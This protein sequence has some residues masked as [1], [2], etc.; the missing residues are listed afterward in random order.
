MEQPIIKPYTEEINYAD[1]RENIQC[2]D[3]L[4]WSTDKS[5]LSSRILTTIVRFFTLSEFSHV[6]IAYREEG[7]VYVLEA[8]IPV[9]QMRLLSEVKGFYHI[10]MRIQW[11]LQLQEYLKHFIGKPYSIIDCIRGY[12]GKTD[13]SDDSWQC[14]EVCNEF[15]KHA[16]IDLGNNY[17]P[18]KVVRAALSNRHSNLLYV[19]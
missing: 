19:E 12:L 8:T 11:D 4:A 6:G 13:V 17:T 1:M 15:F 16:G 7:R 9:I 14:A 2:G 5:S 3:L 18:S 10:P